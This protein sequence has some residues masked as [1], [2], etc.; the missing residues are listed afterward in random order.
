LENDAEKVESNNDSHKFQTVSENFKET[1]DIKV[2]SDEEQAL[3]EAPANA[4]VDSST[5]T[6]IPNGDLIIAKHK[7][8]KDL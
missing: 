8:E 7:D 5:D 4:S 6:I 1:E 3:I 2:L